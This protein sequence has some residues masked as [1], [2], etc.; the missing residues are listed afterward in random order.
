[1]GFGFGGAPTIILGAGLVGTGY[2]SG[3]A[4]GIAFNASA[5]AAGANGRLGVLRIIEF[6]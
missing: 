1:M 6:F 4:G 5:A 3:G 2:G